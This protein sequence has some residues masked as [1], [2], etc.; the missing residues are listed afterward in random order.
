MNLKKFLAVFIFSAV[1]VPA[2]AAVE[3]RNIRWQVQDKKNVS[4]KAKFGDVPELVFSSGNIKSPRFRVAAEIFNN[5]ARS[6][7]ASIIR[8]AFYFRLIKLSDPA[9]PGVWAVP[10]MT[11]ERRVSKIKPGRMN[12]IKIQHVDIRPFLSRLRE[13]GYW[14]DAVKVE[15]MVDPR[16]GDEIAVAES[17]IPVKSR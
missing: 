5:S 13:S 15:C 12:E 9:K 6:A 16:P 14:P 7:D 2:F 11:E 4:A 17:V 3:V 8:C 1:C 10:F